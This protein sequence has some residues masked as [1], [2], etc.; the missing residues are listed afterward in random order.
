[1]RSERRLRRGSMPTE[2]GLCP[3]SCSRPFLRPGQVVTQE[4]GW[5]T[6]MRQTHAQARWAGERSCRGSRRG[7]AGRGGVHARPRQQDHRSATSASP[8]ARR[9]PAAPG[10]PATPAG[11]GGLVR[12]RDRHFLLLHAAPDQRGEALHRPPA[13]TDRRRTDRS[14]HRGTLGQQG[15]RHRFPRRVHDQARD[16]HRSDAAPGHRPSLPRPRRLEPDQPDPLQQRRCGRRPVVVRLRGWQLRAAHP[17][18]RHAQRV[19]LRQ[20]AVLGLH[21]L[22]PARPGQPDGLCARPTSRPTTGTTSCTG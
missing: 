4:S 6:K 22:L 5:S 13:G 10:A 19:L 3:P 14:R 7:P 12:G 1:M 15:R 8:T 18:L 21:V 20:P 11:P 16:H 17:W 2:V 9:V